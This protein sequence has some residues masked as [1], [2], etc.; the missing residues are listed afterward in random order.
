MGYFETSWYYVWLI[1]FLNLQWLNSCL[2][3]HKK[4]TGGGGIW[5]YFFPPLD[6][7]PSTSLAHYRISLV[8][9]PN[10]DINFLLCVSPSWWRQSWYPT[11][12]AVTYIRILA[13][14]SCELCYGL[15]YLRGKLTLSDPECTIVRGVSLREGGVRWRL[16]GIIRR[17]TERKE[18]G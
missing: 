16:R 7:S 5:A 2:L 6:L 14:L 13:V 9:S 18:L 1:L 17:N 12:T 11:H 4:Q 10:S 3:F 15:P 8:T